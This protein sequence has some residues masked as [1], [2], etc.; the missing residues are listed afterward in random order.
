[1][2]DYFKN[3]GNIMTIQLATHLLQTLK[4]TYP[5]D[6]QRGFFF[7]ICQIRGRGGYSA[8]KSHLI[9][10]PLKNCL[11]TIADMSCC[12]LNNFYFV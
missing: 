5:L 7:L 1:M 3:V 9:N 2:F 4:F 8:L 11:K 12:A 6:D 10:P